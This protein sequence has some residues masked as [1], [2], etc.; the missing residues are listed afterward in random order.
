MSVKQE[1]VKRPIANFPPSVWGDQFLVYDQQ[2]DQTGEKLV[3][4]LKEEV[5]KEILRTVN[6]PTEHTNLLKLVNAVER[7]GIVYYFEKEINQALHHFYDEYGDNWTGGATSVWF[8]IMRQHGFFVSGDIFK[9]YKGKDGAFKEPLENDT[10]SLLE[11][12]EATYLRV[13]GEIILDDALAY[14]RRRLDDISKD[15]SLSNSMVSKQIQEALKQPLHKRVPRIEALR[16]IPFYEQQTSHNKSSLKLA[17]LGF[18]LLQSL[19]RKELCHIHKWWKGFNIPSNV[20]YARNR[21]V[22]CYF[23]SLC[24]YFEPQYSQSRMFLAK[25]LALET[26]LDDTY[27]AYG[28]FQELEIFTEAIKRWSV[29]GLDNLPESMKLIHRMILDMYEDMEKILLKM[30]KSHHLDYS[31][32]AMIEYIGCYLKEAEWANDNYI[33]T[34]EEHKQVTIVSSGYKNTLIASFAAMG[35]V[36]TDDTFKWA[37]T[38]PPLLKACC[39]LCRVMDDIVTHKDEQER[40]HVVS[41]IQCYMKEHDVSEQQAYDLLNQKVEEDWKEMNLESLRCKDVER[42]VIMLVI[43]LARAMDVL[44]KNKDHFTHVDEELINHIK[45][46]V[47]E[48]IAI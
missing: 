16:Y 38:M 31:K 14:T 11:L 1:D 2:E 43:N 4:N 26:L 10:E 12:Y 13:P 9:R 30:G 32:E 22:E 39:S 48:T 24:V 46:L 6:I 5:R 3:E 35:D 41:G 34:A 29:T 8:R 23:W 15:P 25:F 18:N 40:M 42:P 7:L 33:P 27:D 17:K 20:P 21:L 28:T 45:S 36:I 44:Y 37:L 47:D 19:H